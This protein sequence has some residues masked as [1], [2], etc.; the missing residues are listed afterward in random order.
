MSQE[1]IQQAQKVIESIVIPSPPQLLFDLTAEMSKEEPEYKAIIDLVSQD[2]AMTAKIIKVANSPFFA[3]RY[4]AS[5][6]ETALSVL[7]LENFKSIV[8]A[9]SLRDAM[10]GNNLTPKEF[11]DFYLHSMQ[12][13]RMAQL[14]A[15][16]LGAS[17]K[18][19][20]QVFMAGL[21]HDC[22]IPMLSQKFPKYMKTIK[23]HV[24]AGEPIVEIEEAFFLT[25]HC[26][27]GIFVARAW[28]IPEMVCHAILSHHQKQI[29][30]SLKEYEQKIQAMMLLAEHLLY[31]G[32][33][34]EL[35]AEQIYHHFIGSDALLSQVLNLL[36]VD[37]S[38]LETLSA[39]ADALIAETEL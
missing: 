31:I 8:L 37:I 39:S 25:N 3:L 2:M 18:Y 10:K 38:L 19:A 22:G 35:R 9:T 5:T 15:Q 6:V 28:Q 4:K 36:D 16:A 27:V 32:L 26:L 33:P 21:F 20:S 29:D 12:V 7:G 13:A 34:E 14:I 11:D 30:P 23:P 24:L 1:L 17:E